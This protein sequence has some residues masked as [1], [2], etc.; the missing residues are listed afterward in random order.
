MGRMR[1]T[2]PQ[3][4]THGTGCGGSRQRASRVPW[5]ATPTGNVL[6]G[7][8][9]RDAVRAGTRATAWWSYYAAT[10]RVQRALPEA[11]Y[12]V[13]LGTSRRDRVSSD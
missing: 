10:A 8:A 6:A 3:D 9:P 7:N 12:G 5:R 11:A 4:R 13:I 2:G 1:Y